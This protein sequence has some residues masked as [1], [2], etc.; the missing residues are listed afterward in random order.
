MAVILYRKS[1]LHGKS[2]FRQM[3]TA[4]EIAEYLLYIVLTANSYQNRRRMP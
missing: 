1:I 2:I 3:F 4:I